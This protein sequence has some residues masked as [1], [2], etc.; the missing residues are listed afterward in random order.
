MKGLSGFINVL[1]PVGLTSHQV[2]AK[3]RKLAPPGTKVGHTGTLDPAATGVLV[4]C[5][6][7]ATRLAD[8]VSNLDKV[9]R[10][11]FTFG[12]RT[13][14]DD[15]KGKVLY[16]PGAEG[17]TE[18]HVQEKLG[19]FRGVFSQ[20][21]PVFSAVSVEGERSYRLARRGQQAE[22]P[23]RLVRVDQFQLLSFLPG[24][25]ARGVFQ[26]RCSSGTYV[27]SLCRDLG[28]ELGCG[29]FVSFLVRVAVGDFHVDQSV[30]LE[31]LEA[32]LPGTGL[33]GYL[34]GIDSALQYMPRVL[35]HADDTRRVRN[36]NSP[37]ARVDFPDGTSVLLCGEGGEVFA[38]GVVCKGMIRVEKVLS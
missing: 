22:L 9:Y 5:L 18:E 8:Y 32:C 23:T 13:D 24:R 33:R 19:L 29:G 31:E 28:E 10:A 17:L 15:V 2:V 1:K 16:A 25:F 21:P 27:R 4:L 34:V 36:G 6:G 20:K 11:E 30:P 3:V 14:T 7:R 37:R 35:L 26:I 38:I 12:A